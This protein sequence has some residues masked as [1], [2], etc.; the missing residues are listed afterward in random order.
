MAKQLAFNT[1]ESQDV[2]DKLRTGIKQLT[3]AVRV[4]LGPSGRVVMYEREFGDPAITKD[5]VTVAKQVELDEPFENMAASMVRQAAAKTAAVAGDG[6]TT[7]TIYSEAIFNAGLKGVSSG[8]DPQ[9]VKRGIDHAT[10]TIIGRLNE[11]AKP[12]VELEQI[13]Q[14][15]ICS[16]NQDQEVGEMIADA[17]DQV[18]RD[19]VVTIEEGRAL[20]TSVNVIDGLQILRG[21]VSPQFATD[22]ETLACE[23]EDPLLLITDEKIVDLK[24]LLAILT[25]VVEKLDRRPLVI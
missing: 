4:T 19:G 21:Y 23:Y 8:A 14:V 15:A 5:G 10:K 24:V 3:D 6:T 12:V 1:A 25:M 9:E 7:A 22:P 20:E 16:A 13:K 17:L 18:G 2:R 11:M